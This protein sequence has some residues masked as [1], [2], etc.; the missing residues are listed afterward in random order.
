MKHFGYLGLSVLYRQTAGDEFCFKVQNL[1]TD[2]RDGIR[3]GQ[4]I[5]V[6]GGQNI[7][8]RMRIPAPSRLQKIHNVNVVF[9]SLV[10]IGI[11]AQVEVRDVVDGR[12]S[13]TL[14]LLWI[15]FNYIQLRKRMTGLLRT[16]VN[17]LR[18]KNS[19]KHDSYLNWKSKHDS[20]ISSLLLEWCSEINIINGA[21]MISNF[22][23]CVDEEVV[24]RLFDYYCSDIVQD[25][26]TTSSI[27]A[28]FFNPEVIS[29]SFEDE[30]S[31]M[32]YMATL[33]S[34]FLGRKEVKKEEFKEEQSAKKIQW[35]FQR[36]RD[37]DQGTT[38]LL[39]SAAATTIQKYLRRWIA[40]NRYEVIITNSIDAA[41]KYSAAAVIQCRWLDIL[42]R[43]MEFKI[44]LE[45]KSVLIIQRT[46][47]KYCKLKASIVIQRVWRQIIVQQ[48]FL[49]MQAR[50]AAAA[51][52][53]KTW[54]GYG[55][56]SKY[57]VL[58]SSANKIEARVRLYQFRKSFLELL[59]AT[60]LV[61]MKH[62]D[63]LIKKWLEIENDASIRVQCN[64]R[65]WLGRKVAMC[66]KREEKDVILLQ[67]IW[68]KHVQVKYYHKILKSTMVLQSFIRKHNVTIDYAVA[69]LGI[70]TLQAYI[71]GAIARKNIMLLS[72]VAREIQ[73]VWR[74]GVDRSAIQWWSTQQTEQ[75]YYAIIKI[76]QTFRGY[77][78]RSM[79]QI[80]HEAAIVIQKE[81]RRRI[82]R[83]RIAIER[84]KILQSA[85]TLQSCVRKH[86]AI[87]RYKLA[88]SRIVALQAIARG[89]AVR[90][91]V[92]LLNFVAKEIQRVWRGGIVRHQ[93]QCWLNHQRKLKNT[94]ALL[95]QR[96]FRWRRVRCT[97]RNENAAA[98]SIQKIIRGTL[99][100]WRVETRKNT[101][102]QSIITIQSYYRKYTDTKCYS[103]ARLGI[104]SFQALVR[105]IT[106]RKAMHSLLF[107]AGEIQR[108]WRGGIVRHEIRSKNKVVVNVQCAFRGHSVRKKI[109]IENE[110]VIVIQTKFLGKSYR[111]RAKI[112][113][114]RAST[115]ALTLQRFV[116][117]GL[118]RKSLQEYHDA[119]VR[120]QQIFRLCTTRKKKI[121]CSIIKIQSVVRM[122]YCRSFWRKLV[123]SATTLQKNYRKFVTRSSFTRVLPASILVQAQ[124]RR[125]FVQKQFNLEKRAALKIATHIRGFITVTQLGHEDLA[126]IEI[127]RLWR[128]SQDRFKY[129]KVLIYSR[130]RRAAI[131]TQKIARGF[132][133]RQSHYT[134]KRASLE[135]QRIW[136]G[137]QSYLVYI[138]NQFASI[139][140]QR[141]FRTFS[142]RKRKLQ[143]KQ[144]AILLQSAWRCY[145]ARLVL[146]V[147]HVENFAATEIQRVWRGA[148]DQLNFIIKILSAVTIQSAIRRFIHLRQFSRW[149]GRV[150]T[151][152]KWV[153]SHLVQNELKRK[154]ISAVKIHSIFR[155][156]IQM[157]KYNYF[158]LNAIIL[159]TWFRSVTHARHYHRQRNA[160][161]VLQAH[162]RRT[163][164]LS[165]VRLHHYA[166]CTIQTTWRGHVA[167][168]NYMLIYLATIRT[169]NFVRMQF[170]RRN[171]WRM[172]SAVL[173]IQKLVRNFHARKLV[174]CLLSQKNLHIIRHIS[175]QISTQKIQRHFR[176]HLIERQ[177]H[178]SATFIQRRV[179]CHLTRLHWKQFK[180]SILLLQS[181]CRGI[182]VR[183]RTHRAKEIRRACFRVHKTNKRALTEPHM[184]LGARTDRSLYI[185]QNGKSLNEVMLASITLE[186]STRLSYLCC[187]AFIEAGAPAIL[188]GVIKTL[189]RSLPHIELLQYIL[190]TLT[191]VA[192]AIDIAGVTT[193]DSSDILV[194]LIQMIRDKDHISVLAIMLLFQI[195]RNNATHKKICSSSEQHKRLKGILGLLKR[196]STRSSNNL[197]K[198]KQ[199]EMNSRNGSSRICSSVLSCGTS[200][201]TCVLEKLLLF[202]K[203]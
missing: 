122:W 28:Q 186:V 17:T 58:I 199:R 69:Q 187:V 173:M 48:N 73:R 170:Q 198:A 3:L 192:E 12:R 34:F 129:W 83:C 162:V 92:I 191:H 33:C 111:N 179:R 66:K 103:A 49:Q 180:S 24:H 197:S 25:D 31:T 65:G 101:I 178:L 102:F 90:E 123:T 32:I 133:Q 166:A 63:Y 181:L 116:R 124:A 74:G 99:Y 119:V 128:A 51:M 130:E 95:V 156:Y 14:K 77:M 108:V 190:L 71:R 184:I 172:K 19:K 155:G 200:K 105:G 57:H 139:I 68:R 100:K 22:A 79:L 202:L 23:S 85:I 152:Q 121:F 134:Q 142:S 5:K 144:G 93:V 35:C 81:I 45:E 42:F 147:M 61:Q 148:N 196:G 157:K 7:V 146:E 194:D 98:T 54:R 91:N 41:E 161:T 64:L 82:Y 106:A 165:Q 59:N 150:T 18:R 141:L 185:L 153:R 163:L 120:I 86:N 56:Y 158:I 62:Q 6:I 76:Q 87:T 1:A 117:G 43:R 140:I 27:V 50:E 160:A 40:L 97:L 44:G 188:F 52:I 136:R 78:V 137:H 131:T 182:A 169:Q 193:E 159:E 201:S 145:Q 46:W 143:R 75:R 114:I 10:H 118:T 113:K 176:N 112:E 135:I 110:N 115:A 16:E 4:L 21:G 96:T 126:A 38:K 30:Q 72:F 37:R 167:H 20:D 88:R 107:F 175:R 94:A 177:K 164:S 138:S 89:I 36:W 9:E 183:R 127:Q 80:E 8:A 13:A 55:F 39:P 132:L 84:N 151:L 154:S 195:C 171:F 47:R 203:K 15:L 125:Q 104:I 149:K 2:L 26:D 53:Q 60:S 11:E 67:C 70:I 174:N 29:S 189:N 168:G 109:D